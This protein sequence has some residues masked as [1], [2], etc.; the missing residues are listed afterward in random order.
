[1][2]SIAAKKKLPARLAA[3]W[4]FDESDGASV[5]DAAGNCHLVVRGA[6]R[7]AG[8]WLGGA[9]RFEADSARTAYLELPHAL[10]VAADLPTQRHHPFTISVWLRGMAGPD[11]SCEILSKADSGEGT[12][13][14]R[15]VVFGV[16]KCRPALRLVGVEGET[17]SEL[18][19]RALEGVPN[20]KAWHHV[21]VSYDGSGNADGVV[22]YVDGTVR[23]AEALGT[24]MLVGETACTA[25]LCVGGRPSPAASGMRADLDDL[26]L[27]SYAV[28]PQYVGVL[29]R[30]ARH[31]RLRYDA[32]QAASLID[33]HR[34]RRGEVR[35]KGRLWRYALGGLTGDLGEIQRRGSQFQIRLHRNG[36]G[37]GSN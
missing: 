35:I 10:A 15:G 24:K 28:P 8:G 14:V 19:V 16:E 23:T 12:A 21:A 6:E 2:V 18:A 25:P 33:L 36:S 30:L 7:I 34:L 9:M 1:L 20:D 22:F 11:G 4:P 27:F 32:K 5:K 26:A 37:V 17:R 13:T 3:C 29:V 31:D